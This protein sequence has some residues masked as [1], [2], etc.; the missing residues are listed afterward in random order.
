MLMMCSLLEPTRLTYR[1]VKRFL[2]LVFSIKDLG[3]A[4]YFLGLEI[5]RSPEGMFLHQRKYVLDILINVGL[6]HGK[7]ASTPMQRS[8]KFSVDS[9]L[10]G[11]PSKTY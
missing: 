7:T 5:T 3:Y 1:H 9:P 6:L 2:H 11:E 4:K 8:H 10:M